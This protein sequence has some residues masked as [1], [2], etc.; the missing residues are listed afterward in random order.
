MI[1]TGSSPSDA[2]SGLDGSSSTAGTGTGETRYVH[3]PRTRSSLVPKQ[4]DLRVQLQPVV[5]RHRG[6]YNVRE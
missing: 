5:V 6:R 3:S 4:R 1:K 2:M